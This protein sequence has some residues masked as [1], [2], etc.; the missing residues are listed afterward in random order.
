M[1]Y[2]I[3]PLQPHPSLLLGNP[4]FPNVT[5]D[6]TSKSNVFLLALNI[7]FM[8]SLTLL[9]FYLLF[10][11][12]TSLGLLDWAHI[13]SSC[14]LHWSLILYLLHVAIIHTLMSGHLLISSLMFPFEDSPSHHHSY[15]VPP[16]PSTDAF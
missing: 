10:E 13:S 7:W 11:T 1:P 8:C 9:T 3:N 14:L 4:V 2:F 16:P 12:F 5:F 15:Y 6:W